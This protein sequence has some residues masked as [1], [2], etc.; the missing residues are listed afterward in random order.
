MDFLLPKAE[1]YTAVSDARKKVFSTGA[2]PHSV[3][4]LGIAL[5]KRFQVSC[6]QVD[7]DDGLNNLQAALV[8]LEDDSDQ[9]PQI[10]NSCSILLTTRAAFQEH[11]D[12]ALIATS[13][14]QAAVLLCVGDAVDSWHYKL[15]YCQSRTLA[16]ELSRH[17]NRTND[18]LAMLEQL[19]ASP[20]TQIAMHICRNAKA[21]ALR[22]LYKW[23]GDETL[24]NEFTGS[25]FGLETCQTEKAKIHVA[26]NGGESYLYIFDRGG[27]DLKLAIAQ[28][29]FGVALASFHKVFAPGCHPYE[30]L[31]HRLLGISAS[32]MFQATHGLPHIEAAKEHFLSALK[33]MGPAHILRNKT[34]IDYVLCVQSGALSQ[35]KTK[36]KISRDLVAARRILKAELTRSDLDSTARRKISYL[37]Q[38]NYRAS[39]TYGLQAQRG[40]ESHGGDNDE[41]RLEFLTDPDMLATGT[42]RL[43][44]SIWGWNSFGDKSYDTYKSLALRFEKAVV[45]PMPKNKSINQSSKLH[46]A[47]LKTAAALLLKLFFAR[48]DKELGLKAAGVC[49]KIAVNRC[50]DCARRIWAGSMAAICLY[51]CLD[52][53]DER[54]KSSIKLS[55]TLLPFAIPIGIRR[56]EQLFLIRK[57]HYTPKL[58]ASIYIAANEELAPT[59]SLLEKGRSMIWDQLLTRQLS[60]QDLQEQDMSLAN[61]W[62]DLRLQVAEAEKSER[63]ISILQQPSILQDREKTLY[64]D[65]RQHGSLSS[66]GNEWDENDLKKLAVSGPIVILNITE[67]R[68]DAILISTTSLQSVPLPKAS[69]ERC[70][71]VYTQLKQLLNTLKGDNIPRDQWDTSDNSLHEVLL[72]LW[73]AI[74]SPILTSLGISV[75]ERP[76]S[77]KPQLWWVTSS[78]ANLLPLHAAGDHRR[79]AATG[80]PCSVLDLTYSS[81]IPTIRALQEARKRM[82]A[83]TVHDAPDADDKA[84]LVAMRTT[85]D[86]RSLPQTKTEIDTVHSAIS[87]HLTTTTLLLHEPSAAQVIAHL[88]TSKIAH[89]ACHG[90]TDRLDPMKSRL[91]FTDH[92]RKPLDV[93]TLIATSFQRCQLVYLSACE[94]TLN[95]DVALLDEGIHISGGF[96]MGGVPN[97]VS[98]WWTVFDDECV[99]VARGFYEGLVGEGGR[100]DVERCAAS[101]SGVMR[102]LR[103]AGRSPLVWAAY[104]HFG[105]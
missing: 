3:A 46:L 33:L 31:L 78:W 60:V 59:I 102:R 99:D 95:E 49:I 12:D 36:T 10:L 71:E 76:E 5:Q 32:R 41:L 79:A 53:I 97:A 42:D 2:D 56:Q 50:F 34:I 30:A 7:L 80:N 68:S 57:L 29:F 47:G 54:T 4:A 66:F 65:I 64:K 45:G 87:H 43:F 84:L 11:L 101:L 88:A 44:D 39:T 98:T 37:L 61:R 38:E 15:Q 21:Y 83:L 93:Q 9:T 19:V 40:E 86:R 23:T 105:T 67:L 8:E 90:E 63:P 17:Q 72:W 104:A 26:L 100:I 1:L 20:P 91:L 55:C 75:H 89:I 52:V 74:V 69:E 28:G 70:R 35:Q 62:R 73:T 22:V 81:Y 94:T 51:R 58:A 25:F 16:Y 6:S 18:V 24:S 48:N 82:Q 14:A 92:G 77:H 27:L 85:P 96:Q 103:D 13:L